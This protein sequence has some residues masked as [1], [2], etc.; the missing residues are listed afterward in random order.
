MRR[1]L[2]ALGVAG[3]AFAADPP[4]E[5]AGLAGKPIVGL[6]AHPAI[7]PRLRRMAAG[8]QRLVSET[9]RGAGPGITWENGWLAGH[10]HTASAHVL[11]GFAPA[12]EQL[13]LMLWE[14]DSPSL[15]IP[16]RYAPWPEGLRGALRRFNPA[17]EAGMRFG[18]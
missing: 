15:F 17:L 14:G 18:T 9:L 16:P 4:E 13:A 11:L 6:A 8:R 12:S 1:A 7:G 10:A 2:L 5:F 3:P